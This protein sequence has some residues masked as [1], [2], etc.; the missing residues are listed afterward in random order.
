MRQ[1]IRIAAITTQVRLAVLVLAFGLTTPAIG[2]ARGAEPVG[3][4]W[5]GQRVVP[6][7]RN[8]V[9][10]ETEGSPARAAKLA[11]YRVDQA[12]GTIRGRAVFDNKDGDLTPGLFGRIRVLGAAMHRGVLLPEEAFATLVR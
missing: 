5:I 1:G 9:L 3:K 2:P 6:K 8:F 12:S 11:I 4:E 7:Y 10:R